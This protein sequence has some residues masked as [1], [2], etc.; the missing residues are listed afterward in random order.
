[1]YSLFVGFVGRFVLGEYPDYGLSEVYPITFLVVS[2]LQDK[3]SF[4]KAFLTSLPH[5]L[6]LK[7]K[8]NY[9]RLIVHQDKI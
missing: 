2:G 1:M 8:T 6:C 5:F 7:L 9:Y 4:F 3:F